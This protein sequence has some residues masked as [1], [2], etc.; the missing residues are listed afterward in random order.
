MTLEEL[1]EKVDDIP[2][3]PQTVINIMALL[4]EPKSAAVDIE[5]EVMKDQ[6][7]TTKMLKM[8]NSAFYSGRRQIKTVAD[9]TVLLGFDT[10]QSLVLASTVGKVMEKELKGYSY[11]RNALW[12][13]SQ[14]SAIMARAIAKKAKYPNPDIAYTAGLLKDVGKVIL[15]EFVHESYQEILKKISNEVMPYVA[16]EEEILGFNHG[17]VGARIVEKWNLASELVD[18]IEFHHKPFQS[19]ENIELVSI[20]HISDGLV[21][22]MGIHEGIDTLGHEFF[23]DAVKILDLDEGD[24]NQIM[25]NVEKIISEEQIFI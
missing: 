5:R 18:A 10:V 13:Q 3:F 12:R 19:M 4:K 20:V 7:L 1:I 16:A 24:L 14:I 25:M 21:M 17:Q 2:A 11:E 22:M 9:A 23:T 15:D 8:A 6:G